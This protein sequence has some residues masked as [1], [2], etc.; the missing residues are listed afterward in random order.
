MTVMAT[1][2]LERVWSFFGPPDLGT[3]AFE[4]L[5]R[6]TVPNDALA[7]PAA[8]CRAKSDL[9]PPVYA[10]DA[11]QL[12]AAMARAVAS[13]PDVTQ[14]EDG[15]LSERYV[16]RTRW[17]RFPDTVVIR[18][19]PEGK[20]RSTL[21]IYSRSQMGKGDMGVN[22]ARVERWLAKLSKEA[23]VAR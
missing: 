15:S 8:L 17:L 14:V 4:T 3:V 13:E 11:P 5:E 10:V 18:Y 9:A 22:K 19:L 7:C 16:Q 20:G 21:A 2:L 12:K 23:P 6:R 1:G